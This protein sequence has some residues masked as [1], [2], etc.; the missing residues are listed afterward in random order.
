[1]YYYRTPVGTFL[2]VERL[3]RW[4]VIF[5]DESLGSYATPQQ[6]ADDL[7]GGHTFSVGK[8]IDASKLGMSSDVGEWQKGT[9]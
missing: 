9:P 2:I 1:M 6:A 3:G 4:H 7:V 8:G 5:N